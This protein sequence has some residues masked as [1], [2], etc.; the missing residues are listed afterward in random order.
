MPVRRYPRARRIAVKT[1]R[2]TLRVLVV[3]VLLVALMVTLLLYS[4]GFLQLALNTGLGFYNDRVPGEIRIG[5]VEGRLID[6]LVL[7]DIF[8]ADRSGRAL[9]VAREL[10]LTWSPWALLDGVVEVAALELSDV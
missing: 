4:P 3:L 1:L 5:R 2:W 9:I 10:T 8:V 7:G 6:R